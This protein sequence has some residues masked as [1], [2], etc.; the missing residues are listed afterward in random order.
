MRQGVELT[1][2]QAIRI[3]GRIRALMMD[4]KQCIQAELPK[5]CS[6]DLLNNLFR[7]PCTKIEALHNDL[8][9]S[10]LTATKYLDRLTD[11]GFF[12]KHR[13]G[14]Y[15]CCI[16]FPLTRIFTEIPDEPETLDAPAMDSD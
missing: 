8:R 6:Q 4:Y 1:A 5:I 15:D 14:R 13:I 2:R 11:E 9:V 3:I 7:H 16:N 12:E 10:R